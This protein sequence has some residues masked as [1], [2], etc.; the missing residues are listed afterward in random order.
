MNIFFH[1]D[2]NWHH[3][4]DP[5]L[6]KKA[7]GQRFKIRLNYVHVISHICPNFQAIWLL[8]TQVISPVKDDF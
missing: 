7:A 2:L 5:I 6:G 3:L 4:I 1:K 8:S